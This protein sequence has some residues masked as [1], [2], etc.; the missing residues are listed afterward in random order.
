MLVSVYFLPRKWYYLG[1]RMVIFVGEFPLKVDVSLD[2]TKVYDESIKPISK[3]A[4]ELV[5]IVPRVILDISYEIHFTESRLYEPFL[6]DSALI[7]TINSN[8][9]KR[10]D[11]LFYRNAAIK[12]FCQTT[13]L[14]NAFIEVCVTD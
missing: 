3:P 13:S 4:A 7:N 10:P 6:H 14:G 5:G 12:G 2:G 1:E 11:G 9:I 8:P